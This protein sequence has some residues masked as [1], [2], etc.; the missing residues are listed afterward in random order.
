MNETLKNMFTK[1][2]T[3]GWKVKEGLLHHATLQ[4]VVIHIQ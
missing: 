1:I 4:L 2:L 3:A